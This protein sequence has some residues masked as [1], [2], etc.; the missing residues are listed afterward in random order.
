MTSDTSLPA[1]EPA[2]VSRQTQHARRYYLDLNPDRSEAL[3]VVCGGV[4]RMKPDYVVS[5]DDF[6]YFAIEIVAEGTGSLRLNDHEFTLTP[7]AAFAY[8]PGLRHRIQNLSVEGMRKYYLDFVGRDALGLLQSAGLHR[9]RPVL[10]SRV[11]ELTDLLDTIGGEAREDSPVARQICSG[12]LRVLLLKIGQRQVSPG[13]D[14]PGSFQT[15]ERARSHMEQNY[16]T[17]SRVDEVAAACQITPIYLSRLFHRFSGTGAYRFLLRLRMNFAAE[18][19]L[20]D[21]R[22]VKEVAEELHYADAFQFSRAFKRVHGVPPRALL[23][24]RLRGERQKTAE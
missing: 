16:L 7:G 8:G 21:G 13:P 18:R 9:C 24:A 23:H 3:V 11:R 4:E 19:L 12:L 6:P 17:L 22:R 1:P 20:V 2:F 10:V 14:V 5:R 15:Y